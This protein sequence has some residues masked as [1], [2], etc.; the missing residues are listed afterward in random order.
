MQECKRN[1]TIFRHARERQG[2]LDMQEKDGALH[3]SKRKTKV[4]RQAKKRRHF[5][6]IWRDETGLQ[7]CNKQTNKNKERNNGLCT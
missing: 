7:F 1:T 6:D 2:F 4:C 5:A 3:T